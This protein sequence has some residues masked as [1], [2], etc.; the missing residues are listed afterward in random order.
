MNITRLVATA[1]VGGLALTAAACGDDGDPAS[2]PSTPSAAST[3]STP[4]TATATTQRSTAST[5]ATVEPSIRP[6]KGLSV[7]RTED[8]S[9]ATQFVTLAAGD[10]WLPNPDNNQVSRVDGETGRVVAEIPVGNPDAYGFS[11][12]P[13]SLTTDPA[14][15]V[16]GGAFSTDSAVRIDPAKNKVVESVPLGID[17]YGL[18]VTK[19]DIWATDFEE[20]EVIRVDRSSGAEIA[21]LEVASPTA[22][23]QATGAV[24]VTG[25]RD[26][27]V[28]RIDPATNEI[29]GTA[30]TSGTLEG[31][32]YHDG[33]LWV[34]SNTG[35]AVERI[36]PSSLEV[37]SIP[38]PYNAYG[39]AAGPDG[40]WA[41]ASAPEG[42]DATN[43]VVV[44]IDPDREV[45]KAQ[46]P[47]ECA[48]A[49]AAL[50]GGRAI[51]QSDTPSA[52][53]NAVLRWRPEGAAE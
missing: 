25:H 1:F 39:I 5:P 7:V 42:C 22:I 20:N 14:G 31:M 36:D 37:T 27:R 21:R 30:Q 28:L 13:Q 19:T 10:A 6:T 17:P 38:L 45:V 15:Q 48:F 23:L 33:A 8:A 32:V 46:Y 16:W 12:D 44:L 2:T 49:V 24:W 3:A 53:T 35:Q 47:V 52:T 26:G 51:V 11:P 18:A 50:A 40:I 34:A 29:T 43:S 4:S 41:T 9:F